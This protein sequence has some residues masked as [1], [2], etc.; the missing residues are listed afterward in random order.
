MSTVLLDIKK[1]FDTIDHEI[2]QQKLDYYVVGEEE[3][4][5][6]KSYLTNRKQ[7]CNMNNQTSSSKVI[8][9]GV[10][11][12]S[13][14]APLLFVIFIKNLTNCVE[15]GHITMYADNTN[16]STRVNDVKILKQR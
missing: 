15:N 10:P 4:N 5:L 16:S 11:Q 9:S 8:K 6:F 12:G 7:C 3:L 2:L 14:L 13:I 1:A